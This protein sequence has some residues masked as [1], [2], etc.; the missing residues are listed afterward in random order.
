LGAAAVVGFMAEFPPMG[1]AVPTAV[2]A[3]LAETAVAMPRGDSLALL[4]AAIPELGAVTAAAAVASCTAR[5]G[6]L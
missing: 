2:V 5:F 3:A 6:A 1:T 4:E